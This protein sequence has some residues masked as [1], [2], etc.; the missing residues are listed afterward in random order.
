MSNAKHLNS[1]NFTQSVEQGRDT[2]SE[3]TLVP[4]DTTLASKKWSDCNFME[5]F[6]GRYSTHSWGADEAVSIYQC[7]M[8]SP[9]YVQFLS[10]I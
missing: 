6:S 7:F 8:F 2:A 10:G 5:S 9:P 3:D 1:P 4:G